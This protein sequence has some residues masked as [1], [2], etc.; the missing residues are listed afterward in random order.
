[1]RHDYIVQYSYYD[2]N[3]IVCIHRIMSIMISVRV[4]LD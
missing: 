2:D 4:I 1:M 3:R